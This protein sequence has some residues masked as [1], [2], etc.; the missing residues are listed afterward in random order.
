LAG[1]VAAGRV[2]RRFGSPGICGRPRPQF[3]A[4][5]RGVSAIGGPTPLSDGGTPSLVCGISA[6]GR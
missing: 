3:D 5:V 4:A 6:I 2:C 1:D